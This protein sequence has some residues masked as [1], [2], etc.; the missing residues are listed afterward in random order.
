MFKPGSAYLNI[1]NLSNQNLDVFSFLSNQ[2]ALARLKN[3]SVGINSEQ[4]FM[5]KELTTQRLVIALPTHSGNFG[6]NGFFSGFSDY[7]ETSIGLAYARSL[8][9]KLELGVQFN[10]NLLKIAG[11]GNT[12]AINF[13]LGTILHLSEQLNASIHLY[14][15]IGGKFGKDNQEKILSIYSAG[16]GFEPSEK[17]LLTTIIE[18]QEGELLNVNAGFQYKIL[19]E[20][21]VRLGY[22]SAASSCFFGLGY[23][24]KNI[25]LHATAS[26]H[27]QLGITP[28]LI[29][30]FNSN[31][32]QE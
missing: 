1:T 11:Y 13:E 2:A 3:I 16:F 7:S 15:P 19:Q 31:R 18:K 23:S 27:Q 32:K 29:F 5:L 17:F 8:G 6:L 10:Y 21:L 25:T 26:Y 4:R 30:I 22:S 28:G 9:D 14:N 12:P 20:V 24:W